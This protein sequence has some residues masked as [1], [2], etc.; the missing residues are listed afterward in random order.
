MSEYSSTMRKLIDSLKR[1]PGIGPKS[2]QRLAF[3]VLESPHSE[4]E[5]LTFAIL[6]AKKKI[7]NCS[8]CFNITD[9]DPCHICSDSNRDKSILCI[10]EEPKDLMAIE[11][12]RSFNG[13]YHILGGAI[14][15]L[16]GINP[17]ALTIKELLHRISNLKITEIVLAM[18]PT[19]E[20]EVTAMYITKLIS[21]LGIKVTR[22]A[23]GIP[24]GADLDYADEV[25][26][27]KSVEGRREIII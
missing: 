22:I 26:L 2:A 14:S 15:P 16:D 9:A 3:Y 18:N 13:L 20:G 10:V 24:I 19:T 5:E 11:R 4:I 23:Y 21:P 1:L 12:S 25:T 8:Q 6:E 7:R 27:T 17:E